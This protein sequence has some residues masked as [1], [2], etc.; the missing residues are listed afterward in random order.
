MN[1]T[2]QNVSGIADQGMCPIEFPSIWWR[3]QRPK[4]RH[5]RLN[6]GEAHYD[7]SDDRMRQFFICPSANV[8]KND[9]KSDDGQNPR[10]E[11]TKLVNDEPKIFSH[12]FAAGKALFHVARHQDSDGGGNHPSGD[13]KTSVE[14][15]E[16][17]AWLYST[18]KRNKIKVDYAFAENPVYAMV[19]NLI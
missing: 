2:G 15:D 10:N 18:A 13:H 5:E 12:H 6:K 17:S 19:I 1:Y 4:E 16:N 7:A 3:W 11:H 8:N 9:D 14:L